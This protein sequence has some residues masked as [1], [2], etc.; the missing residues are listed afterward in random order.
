MPRTVAVL[1]FENKNSTVFN[2]IQKQLPS[3]EIK[4]IQDAGEA[5]DLPNESCCNGGNPLPTTS[6]LLLSR[7]QS[8]P[9]SIFHSLFSS[10]ITMLCVLSAPPKKDMQSYVN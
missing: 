8:R 7:E 10:A 3:V 1:I 4:G 9:P 6:S 2:K 5:T